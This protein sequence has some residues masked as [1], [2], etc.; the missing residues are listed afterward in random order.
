VRNIVEHRTFEPLIQ[1][2]VSG[3]FIYVRDLKKAIEMYSKLFGYD[4]IEQNFVSDHSYFMDNG[5]V[6]ESGGME[7]RPA[8]DW[9]PVSLKLSTTDIDQSKSFVEELGF[10]IMYEIDRSPKVSWFLF[11]DMDGNRF[12]MCQDH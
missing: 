5:V 12:M 4:V 1:K 9:F 3:Y 10:K 8:L 7:D 11:K 2:K 6:L